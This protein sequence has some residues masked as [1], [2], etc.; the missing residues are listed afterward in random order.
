VLALLKP[1]PSSIKRAKDRIRQITQQ[2]RGRNIQ[3][4][5]QEVNRYTRGWLNYFKLASVKQIFKELDAWL[6]R[7]LRKILWEQWIEPRTRLK[8]LIA[9][10]V[11]P[12]RAK[13]ATATGLGAW[14]NAGASHMHSAVNNG[15]LKDWGL[16]N[17]SAYL[18]YLKARQIT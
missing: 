14:W 17:L 13:K 5:I 3:Q 15:L 4:V 18:D 6:R 8:K 11:N 10:G 9:L 2:G 1:A 12:I 7:R 16:L